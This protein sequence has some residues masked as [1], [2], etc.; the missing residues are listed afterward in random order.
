[1]SARMLLACYSCC[2]MPAF[3]SR[4]MLLEIGIHQVMALGQDDEGVL[5]AQ[6]HDSK[7]LIDPFVAVVVQEQIGLAANEYGCRLLPAYGLN[8]R[9]LIKEDFDLIRILCRVPDRIPEPFLERFGI[10]VL[11]SRRDFL[12]E[13][14]DATRFLVPRAHR[15][16]CLARG[17][18]ALCPFDLGHAATLSSMNRSTLIR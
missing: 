16:P 12:A 14:P 7:H 8:Q 13:M 9:L 11:A 5:R 18:R 2:D 3:V 10:A 17:V 6:G 15:V 4:E 1:M